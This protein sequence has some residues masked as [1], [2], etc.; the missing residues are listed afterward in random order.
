[1]LRA[2]S[3]LKDRFLSLSIDLTDVR[4][5]RVI[6]GSMKTTVS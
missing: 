5:Q 6:H 3:V 4:M 1:M 2:K